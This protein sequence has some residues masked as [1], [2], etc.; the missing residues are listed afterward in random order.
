M[1]KMEMS[2]SQKD[3]DRQLQ[4]EEAKGRDHSAH[5]EEVANAA[6]SQSREER[7]LAWRRQRWGQSYSTSEILS[8]T[9][10]KNKGALRKLA[11]EH[12]GH[13]GLTDRMCS[14]AKPVGPQRVNAKPPKG[15][16]GFARGFV[17]DRHEPDGAVNVVKKGG[18]GTPR[19]SVSTQSKGRTD[20]PKFSST[21]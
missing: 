7:A 9:A 21:V 11:T 15:L 16:H 14:L 20:T 18:S 17:K 13:S 3:L 6:T 8:W 2:P 10:D 4:Y 5:Q 19:I 1:S 12:F